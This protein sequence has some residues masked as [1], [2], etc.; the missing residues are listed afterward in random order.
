MPTVKL[1]EKAIARIKAPDPSGRQ[2]L[3][4]DTKLKGFGVRASGATNDKSYV[5]QGSVSGKSRRITVG[6]CN[7]LTLVE[8]RARPRVPRRLRPRD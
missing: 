5:V 1:T 6:P 7:V 4:W 3:H 2:V 8:A